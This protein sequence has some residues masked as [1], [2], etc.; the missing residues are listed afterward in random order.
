MA[1]YGKYASTQILQRCRREVMLHLLALLS[2][3]LF[4]CLKKLPSSASTLVPS[5]AK[6]TGGAP[7]SIVPTKCLIW[8]S[9]DLGGSAV[10]N[11]PVMQEPQETQVQSLGQ[12]VPLE[13]GRATLSSILA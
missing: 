4:P 7:F 1:V 10:K 3:H 11:L 9:L 13:K 2:S 6:W 8:D 12:K 5:S